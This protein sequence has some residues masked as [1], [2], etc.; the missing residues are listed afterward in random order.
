MGSC[1]C[2]NKKSVHPDTHYVL[3]SNFYNNSHFFPFSHHLDPQKYH[4]QKKSNHEK[5]IRINF[6]K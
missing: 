1:I 6:Y 2:Y 4:I 5:A 3:K